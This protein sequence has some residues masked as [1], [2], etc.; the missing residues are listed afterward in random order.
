METKFKSD[1]IL[2]CSYLLV[3]G[4]RFIDVIEDSPH[5]FVFVFSSAETCLKLKNKF[6][7]NAMAPAQLLFAKR[8]I[9]I[10]EIKNR[11][12]NKYERS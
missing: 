3:Q 1:D 8:E 7:N 11:N 4:V 12:K 2:L 5:H 9:L 6:V 10:S